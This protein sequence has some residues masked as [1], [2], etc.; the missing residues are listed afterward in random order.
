MSPD[1]DQYIFN[2]PLTEKDSDTDVCIEHSEV[3]IVLLSDQCD[4]VYR[5][6]DQSAHKYI[7]DEGVVKD[8]VYD[9]QLDEGGQA[10]RCTAPRTVKPGDRVKAAWKL[11]IVCK[12]KNADMLKDKHADKPSE[13]DQGEYIKYPVDFFE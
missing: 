8:A 6:V 3:K 13:D 10:V 7:R 1:Q 9:M 5:G 11:Y 2:D 12:C 4:G